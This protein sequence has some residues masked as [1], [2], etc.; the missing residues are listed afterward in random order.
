MW[1]VVRKIYVG[2][3]DEMHQTFYTE[4]SQKSQN[5]IDD[6]LAKDDILKSKLIKL[7]WGQN[8]VGIRG[9]VKAGALAKVFYI[10]IL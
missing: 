9:N 2:R 7:L 1:D 3:K 4:K 5:D 10:L 6:I 8:H